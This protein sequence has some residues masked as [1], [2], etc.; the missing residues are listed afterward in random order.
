MYSIFRA[1]E[2]PIARLPC[3]NGPREEGGAGAG[4]RR[5]MRRAR[6]FLWSP[7][8]GRFSTA[9]TR[10]CLKNVKTPKR[11]TFFRRSALI[12]LAIH[13][14]WLRQAA[15]IGEKISRRWAFRHL[16]NKAYLFS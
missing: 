10:P 15:L 8:H 5:G 14:V 12:F 16:S 1:A 9:A 3:V 6:R 2:R 4:A 11:R 13:K 7:P